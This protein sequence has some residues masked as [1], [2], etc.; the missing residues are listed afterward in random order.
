[1]KGRKVELPRVEVCE[2]FGKS[3]IAIFET[4]FN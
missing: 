3:V 1:M 4:A 2:I